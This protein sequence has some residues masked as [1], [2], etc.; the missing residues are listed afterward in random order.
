MT[1][2]HTVWYAAGTE[3]AR[4]VGVAA[5]MYSTGILNAPDMSTAVALSIAALFGSLAAGFRVLQKFV[6]LL[7]WAKLV[8]DKTVA[9]WADAFTR[10]A[11]ASFLVTITGWLAAPDYGTWRSV[12]LAAVTGG[13]LAGA[14]ALQGLLTPGEGPLPDAGIGT[15]A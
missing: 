7:T 14:R 13:L 11:V 10:A 3:L 15:P 12:A 9:S 6:P 4:A 5:L 2:A 1:K 8:N